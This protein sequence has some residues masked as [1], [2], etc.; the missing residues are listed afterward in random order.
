MHRLT[1]VPIAVCNAI[2][3]WLSY[4]DRPK[5][6]AWYP[7]AFVGLGAV[8]VGCYGWAVGR[9]GR[10]ETFRFNVTYDLVMLVAYYAVPLIAGW[11]KPNGQTLLA[12]VLV[13]VAAWLLKGSGD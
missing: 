3:A 5:A 6:A 7:W 12:A 13:V 11:V 8:T 10:G 1:L 2:G 4:A 9:C